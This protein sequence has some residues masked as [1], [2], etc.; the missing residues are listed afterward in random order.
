VVSDETKALATDWAWACNKT[1]GKAI[2][3]VKL[4]MAYLDARALA[5]LRSA[6]LAIKPSMPLALI[7]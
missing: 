4:L 1:A 7:S 5:L 2:D 3:A 6:K